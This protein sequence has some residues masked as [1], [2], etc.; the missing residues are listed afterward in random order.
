[1]YGFSQYSD[2]KLIFTKKKDINSYDIKLTAKGSGRGN[3]Q[4]AEVILNDRIIFK[5][6]NFTR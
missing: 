1:M 6:G 5:N 3:H 2:T 4:N